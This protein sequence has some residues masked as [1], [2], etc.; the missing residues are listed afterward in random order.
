MSHTEF[1]DTS[2]VAYILVTFT[3][4]DNDSSSDYST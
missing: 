1:C 2:K 3:L 4:V